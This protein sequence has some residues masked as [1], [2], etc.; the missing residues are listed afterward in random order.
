M[1]LSAYTH[2]RQLLQITERWLSNQ[3]AP[4]DALQI[5]RIITY[6]SFI[7]WHT[8]VFFVQTLTRRLDPA[9]KARILA[10]SSPPPVR[11]H[12]GGPPN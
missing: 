12:P 2:R 8:L 5:T 3:L 1:Y 6:D 11:A 4:D 10:L 9:T 7:A